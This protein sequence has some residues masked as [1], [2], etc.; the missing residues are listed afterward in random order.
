M[1]VTA[2]YIKPSLTPYIH[3][4]IAPHVMRIVDAPELDLCTD[5]VR[6]GA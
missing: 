4:V 2:Q 1:P 3:D 5:P 6:V